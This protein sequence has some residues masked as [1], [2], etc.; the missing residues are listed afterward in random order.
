MAVG[1]AILQVRSRELPCRMV[2]QVAILGNHAAE[3]QPYIGHRKGYMGGTRSAGD[4]N[5]GLRN[6]KKTLQVWV[7]GDR[8]KVKVTGNIHS[9][10]F[11]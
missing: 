1:R 6:L 10:I 9:R 3:G 7:T 2:L 5:V 4:D 11:S 8:S